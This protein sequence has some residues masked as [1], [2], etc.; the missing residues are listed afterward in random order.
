M[1]VQPLGV[2]QPAPVVR[3]PWRS[4][5]SH[6]ANIRANVEPSPDLGRSTG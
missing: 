5:I 3:E 1:V 4:V 2:T 6:D